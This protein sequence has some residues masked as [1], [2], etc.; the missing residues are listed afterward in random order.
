MRDFLSVDPDYALWI[1]LRR[2]SHVVW[3]VRE[4]ELGQYGLSAVKTGVLR[5]VQVIGRKAT[6]AEISRY[7]LREDHSVSGLLSRM[8]KEGLVTKVKD[9]DKKNRV[10][11]VLTEKGHKAYYQAMKGGSIH[12]IM[13]ALSDEERQQFMSCLEKIRDKAFKELGWAAHHPLYP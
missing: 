5:I 3:K 8:E 12:N 11:I 2:T 13:S 10:R 6:P 7:L 9:L 1:L 4:R